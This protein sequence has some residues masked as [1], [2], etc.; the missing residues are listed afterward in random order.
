MTHATGFR[1]AL[2][3]LSAAAAALM[4]A[5]VLTLVGTTP[6]YAQAAG[7]APPV[8]AGSINTG[9]RPLAGI[10]DSNDAELLRALKG[11]QGQVTIQDEKSAVLIQPQGRDWRAAIKGPVRVIGAWLV[12]GMVVV[13]IVFF[14]M[15]GRITIDKGFSGRTIARFN[16]LDR[17][18]HWLTASSFVVLALSGLN[19]S[20]GRYLLLPIIGP[21][22]FTG[23]S[24][25]LKYAHNFVALPFM[26]GVVVMFVLWVGHNIPNKYDFQWLAVAGGLFSKGAHPPSKKFNAGQKIIF[27]SVILG[28]AIISVSGIFLLF[29]FYFGDIHDQQLMQILHAVFALIL[30][31]IVLAHIYIG[32]LGMEGAFDA[33]YT[34]EVDENWAREHHNVW[35]AQVKGEP[36]PGHD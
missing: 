35:V 21:D 11:A 33:M 24:L 7:G 29:P 8:S 1:A 32:S 26:V 4:L 12:L 23:L 19:I 5:A 3:R 36:V 27:W 17:F 25:A 2:A 15:R 28:G 18:T 13:L 16:G 14:L 31:S 10:T 20:Y 30:I 22:A 9:E 6:A 34:G